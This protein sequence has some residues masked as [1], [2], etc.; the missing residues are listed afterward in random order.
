MKHSFPHNKALQQKRDR[1]SIFLFLFCGA[2]A[3]WFTWQASMGRDQSSK[4][5]FSLTVLVVLVV[6]AYFLR[7]RFSL[8][9]EI[10]INTDYIIIRRFRERDQH[11]PVKDVVAL[12][13]YEHKPGM[14]YLAVQRSK[15]S[16][17][18]LDYSNE[19]KEK[20][21]G[22]LGIEVHKVF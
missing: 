1:M 12:L 19:L 21:C 13:E 22:T 3:V 15:G 7:R 18:L 16:L 14:S 2:F 6:L 17:L 10:E 9:S 5:I 11:V 4:A 20:L 8:I